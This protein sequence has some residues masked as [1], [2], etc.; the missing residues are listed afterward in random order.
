MRTRNGVSAYL[1][2]NQ[3]FHFK[4][5]NYK[6]RYN[7]AFRNFINIKFYIKKTI[8]QQNHKNK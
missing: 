6:K 5:K 1:Y 7:Y 2:P 4:Q 3:V 8:G